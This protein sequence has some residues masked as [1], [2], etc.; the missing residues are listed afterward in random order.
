MAVA[1]SPEPTSSS[2]SRDQD[3]APSDLSLRLPFNVPANGDFATYLDFLTGL[4]PV[5]TTVNRAKIHLAWLYGEALNEF[6][7]SPHYK[8]GDY[9]RLLTAI[10]MS[11][12]KAYYVRD[13]ARKYTL[14]NALKFPSYSDLLREMKH[15]P[16][17][18]PKHE[19]ERGTGDHDLD[20]IDP[21]PQQPALGNDATQS[22]NAGA[23][24]DNRT[25]PKSQGQRPALK[26]THENVLLRLEEIKAQL[27]QVKVMNPPSIELSHATPL[28]DRIRTETI[29]I[30]RLIKDIHDIAERWVAN[31]GALAPPKEEAQ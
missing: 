21:P 14:E 7:H 18:E 4:N 15:L 16:D 24:D 17:R 22:D 30:Q 13:I 31:T 20:Q 27:I 10:E 12:T 1:F 8:R 2:A 5:A 6:L 23:D 11:W 3:P 26:V 9:G 25:P 29:E 19:Q 28:Y